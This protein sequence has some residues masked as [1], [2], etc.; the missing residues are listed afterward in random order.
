MQLTLPRHIPEKIA[1]KLKPKAEKQVKSGHPWIFESSIV[2][3]NKEGSPGDICVIFD[4]RKNKFL[5][6]GLL[7]PHSPIRIKVL[8]VGQSVTLNIDYWKEKI[9]AAYRHRDK[10]LETDTNSYRLIYGENDGMPG[11][12]LD[13]YDGV[14][15]IKLYST[16]WIPYFEDIVSALQ[17]LMKFDALVLR[18]SRSVATEVSDTL[19]MKDGMIID[20]TLSNPEVVFKEYGLSF[21]ANVIKGHKTGYFLDHRHNRRKV[22]LMSKGKSVLDVFSYAGGFTVHALAGG[23]KEV[24]SLDIS[25]QAQDMA[26]KNVALN[27]LDT[28]KHKI[29]IG[30]AFTELDKL[31]ANRVSYDNVVIDPPSFAK[32]ATEIQ[33]A[34]KSYYKLALQGVRLVKNNGI[35]VLAS[36]SSRVSKEQFFETVES[37]IRK[38]SK[39]K[40]LEYTEHDLDH[41]IGFPE[42]A[43]LKCGYYKINK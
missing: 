27:N 13:V 33:G 25:A 8:N 12:I 35:L 6:L 11:F 34:L 32:K 22:G 7:D 28:S 43:Y 30:D 19:G 3:Q 23:A 17:S 21:S 37:A 26:R 15:V 36:C 1:V 14:F 5:A 40:V 24:T 4:Q 29:I 38:Y 31:V 39:L 42:G 9:I 10:L 20:G 41:P 16:I 18:L 2:K